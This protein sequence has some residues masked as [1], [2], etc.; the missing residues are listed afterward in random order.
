MPNSTS[1]LTRWVP[2]GEGDGTAIIITKNMNTRTDFINH[3]ITKRGYKSYLEIG[4]FK[5]DN[6]ERMLNNKNLVLKVGVDPDPSSKATVF[7]T[8]DDYFKT[9]T[10]RFD[11]VFIDGMHL[12]EFVLRDI[13]NSLR[14]L[15]PNGLIVC[16]D[17][18]PL[19]ESMQRRDF[20]NKWR[21]AWNGDCWRAFAYYMRRSPFYCYTLRFDEG[22]GI[23][24][25][26]KP[27][28][29][30]EQMTDC[31][32]EMLDLKYEDF[33]KNMDKWMNV[34]PPEFAYEAV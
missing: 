31:V 7:M 3:V 5:G 30:E 14:V 25:T 6:F 17:M 8:S 13:Q 2:R 1:G 23:I 22:L 26:S 4:V 16:H 32:G 10:D 34:K 18:L 9:C 20:E 27:S 28:S 11:I 33:A 24:D 15:N 21:G 12:C 19:S 29:L